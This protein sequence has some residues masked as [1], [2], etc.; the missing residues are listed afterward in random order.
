MTE[1]TDYVPNDFMP[2]GPFNSCQKCGSLRAA[3]LKFWIAVDINDKTITPRQPI[4]SPL[5]TNVLFLSWT[6]RLKSLFT[7]KYE[8]RTAIG[9]VD[10]NTEFKIANLDRCIVMN[11]VGSKVATTNE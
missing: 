5:V 4:D 8:V 10:H 6:D 9:A 7:R 11:T 2:N 1:C 3:H